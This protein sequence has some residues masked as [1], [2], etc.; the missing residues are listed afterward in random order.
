MPPDVFYTARGLC[1]PRAQRLTNEELLAKLRELFQRHGY[2]SGVIINEAEGVQ[3]AAVYIHRYGSLIRAY[4]TVGF[5]PER[6]Y[7]YLEVNQCIRRMHPQLVAQTERAISDVAGVVTRDSATDLLTVN[8][9]FSV[10]LVLSRCQ[11]L[12]NGRRRWK[13]RFDTGLAP[14]ITVAVRLNE[15]NQA[16]LDYYLLPRLDFGKVGLSLAERNGIEVESYRFE[17]LEYLYS[18]AERSRIRR[19][20]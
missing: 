19:A 2:L 4:Q 9:E 10:S 8:D 17:S 16:A 5:S 7:R 6:D 14:D 1:A 15:S 3:S 11:V 18:M 20:A 13:I 12:G